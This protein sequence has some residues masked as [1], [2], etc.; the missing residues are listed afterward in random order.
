MHYALLVSNLSKGLTILTNGKSDLTENQLNKLNTHYISVIETPVTQILHEDG[1]VREV[2][3]SDGTKL[4]F[5]AIYFR[6]D[7]T[8]S[9]I[10]LALGCEF[11][12]QGYIKIDAVQKTSVNNIFACGDN[13]PIMRAFVNAVV[14]GNMTGA[15]VNR[16]LVAEKF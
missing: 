14:T 1:H 5:S 13:S 2:A 4:P 11:T 6:P 3:L 8:Q 12:E 7:F 16:E 9:E 10:P 15:V